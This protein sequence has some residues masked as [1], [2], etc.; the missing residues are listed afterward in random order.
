[1]KLNV[2]V[3]DSDKPRIF[4]FSIP[5]WLYLNQLG[6]S[7]IAMRRD[8]PIKPRQA[9]RCLRAVKKVMRQQGITRICEIDVDTKGAVVHIDL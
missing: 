7:L 6:V 5:R 8:V 2:S 3:N 4:S 1:M 9:R